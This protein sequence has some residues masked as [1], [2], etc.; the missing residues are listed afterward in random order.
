MANAQTAPLKKE[1]V[2]GPNEQAFLD[3]EF[4]YGKKY[5]FQLVEE[6][7]ERDLPVIDMRT[8]RPAYVEKFK[9][10]HNVVLTSQIVWNGARRNVRYY[11]GCESIFVDEQPKEKDMI[12]Q[13]IAQT[14]KIRFINGKLGVYGDERY[15]LMYLTITGW[16]GE[17]LFRTKT[18]STVFISVNGDKLVS[19][20]EARLDASENALT[21]AKNASVLKM[22]IHSSFL[23]LPTEDYDSGN[24]LTEKE[25]RVA[26]RK[27]A[28]KNPVG[29]MKSYGDQTIETRY[30]V[31]KAVQ[32]GTIHNKHN[33]N[34]ATWGKSNAV[35]CDVS[36]L[37][38]PEAI[39]NR[40]FEF[41]QTEEGEEFLIQ[42][43]Q[44]YN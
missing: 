7:K 21:F 43:K 44:L 24:E 31:D 19:A 33:P 6:N 8:R 22:K 26:Y 28:L 15:L 27:E 20:E 25:M 38:S 40:V 32:A 2:N 3:M 30:Y 4:D 41:S 37:S 12:D 9:P 5:M 23:G 1:R 36:G 14:K 18:A 39:S 35:I 10:L 42:L 34:K 11:D 16:N 17:S 13:L 29:F